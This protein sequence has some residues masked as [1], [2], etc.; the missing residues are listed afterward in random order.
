MKLAD[1]IVELMLTGTPGE[2]WTARQLAEGLIVPRADLT[3]AIN[4]LRY[5]GKLDWRQLKL[6][7]SMWI[8]RIEQQLTVE[9]D[10]SPLATVE[11]TVAAPAEVAGEAMVAPATEAEPVVGTIEK[12]AALQML[13]EV[14]DYCART[15]THETKIG[16]V[17][18]RHPGFIGLVRHRAK[19]GVEKIAEVRLLMKQYPDGL[20]LAERKT[21]PASVPLS[22][23]LP[24]PPPEPVAVAPSLAEQVHAE[25]LAA[26]KQRREA[27][28]MSATRKG[29][30]ATP[31]RE[32][33]DREFLAEPV[34]ALSLLRR[35][36]PDLLDA[37]VG[38]ARSRGQPVAEAVHDVIEGGLDRLAVEGRKQ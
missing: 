16:E 33:I 27:R 24:P 38:L 22:K 13:R 2:V 34:D 17:L 3:D 4:S 30:V 6:M 18:Y 9:P 23:P 8:G 7:P 19:A 15:G 26:G 25:A 28:N 10:A 1:R 35:R 32:A 21:L 36:W 11:E 14:D 37:L 31:L 12:I 5:A 29:R 20:V